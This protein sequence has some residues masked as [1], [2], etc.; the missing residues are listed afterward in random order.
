MPSLRLDRRI[1][2]E[3]VA[4]IVKVS[5]PSIDVRLLPDAEHPSAHAIIMQLSDLRKLCQDF[6]VAAELLA[7]AR[8]SIHRRFYPARLNTFAQF[9]STMRHF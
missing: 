7:F 2:R 5:P 1:H 9:E 6:D 8:R 3:K 4:R